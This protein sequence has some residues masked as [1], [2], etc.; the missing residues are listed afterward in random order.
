MKSELID[1]SPAVVRAIHEM[2]LCSDPCHCYGDGKLSE[3]EVLRALVLRRHI[4]FADISFKSVLPINRTLDHLPH[5]PVWALGAAGVDFL[6]DLQ[7]WT[8]GGLLSLRYVGVLT[9]IAIEAEMAKHGLALKDGDPSRFQHLLEDEPKPDQRPMNAAPDELRKQ[10]GEELMVLGK[11]LM[12]QGG[13]IMRISIRA[14]MREKVGG[15]LAKSVRVGHGANCAVAGI[16]NMLRDLEQSKAT[17]KRAPKP[18]RGRVV[19][20]RDN[21]IKGAF[22]QAAAGD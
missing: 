19:V 4:N 6:P 9:A 16:A 1:H 2:F 5:S 3:D 21:V 12:A 13:T 17:H 22:P 10:C 15:V 11:R 7:S 14:M 20:E 18:H 8:F